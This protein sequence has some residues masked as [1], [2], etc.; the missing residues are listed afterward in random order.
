MRKI[1]K[2]LEQFRDDRNWGKHHTP[3]ELAR[4]LSIEAAE[5]NAEFL[6][7]RIPTDYEVGQEIADVMIYALNI[8]AVMDLDP[9]E[10]IQDKIKK[11]AEK[12]PVSNPDKTS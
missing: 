8:C 5:L 12:Y 9:Y 11:N 6:W 3:A 2:Q 1:I 7:G 10:I 4:A